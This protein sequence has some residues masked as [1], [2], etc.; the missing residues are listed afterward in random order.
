MGSTIKKSGIFKAAYKSFG[1]IAV[2]MALVGVVNAAGKKMRYE[3]YVP[4]EIIVKFKDG[5]NEKQKSNIRRSNSMQL[6]ETK[7]K[8]QVLNQIGPANLERWKLDGAETVEKIQAELEKLADVKYA[9]PNFY[10]Y[11]LAIPNDTSYTRQWGLN[12]TGQPLDGVTGTAGS[13]ME[14]EE[15]WDIQTGSSAVTVAVVDDGVQINHPDLSGNIGAGRD[16]INSDSDASPHNPSV[17]DHGTNAAGV[18]GAVGNNGVGVTGVAWDVTIMPVLFAN[19]SGGTVADA[20]SAFYWARTNGA[21]IINYSYGSMNYS[22]TLVDAI[23]DL[24]TNGVLLVVPAGNGDVNNDFVPLYPSN[25]TNKNI[26]AVAS[27]S[28]SDSLSSWS[29]YGQTSVDV[30]APGENVCTTTTS[31]GYDCDDDDLIDGTSF[32]APYVAGVAALIK[33]QHTSADYQEIKGRIMAGVDAKTSARDK[34]ASG[35]RVNAENALLVTE[36]EVL[37]INSV[38]V[39]ASGNGIIDPSETADLVIGIENVWAD[40]T[41][42]AAVLSS[43]DSEI[44]IAEA[45]KTYGNISEGNS[46]TATFSITLGSVSGYRVI[47]FQLDITADGY[48]VTRYFNLITGYLENNTVVNGTIQSSDY[49]DIHYYH[50]NVPTG[51]S[52]ITVNSTCDEDIDLFVMRGNRPPVAYYGSQYDYDTTA[53]YESAL[54]SSGNE[55]VTISNPTPG[56]YIVAVYN[57]DPTKA[58]NAYTIKRQVISGGGGVDGGGGGGNISLL[59]SIIL[60]LIGCAMRHR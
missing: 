25:H 32:S 10:V 43:S 11:P 2:S 24:E 41:N 48:S 9:E 38:S 6:G 44:S 7:I 18:L 30:M 21:Q 50:F 36:T 17:S 60:G 45:N 56:D 55:Q 14:M 13:D 29:Q 54:T 16:I 20:V 4:G 3:R 49:D 31:S 46:A 8:A 40:S 47:P 33:S 26:I 23:A 39:D 59:I 57:Y 27:S 15:A 22:Q 37:V 12:N 53:S 19:D 58:N 52:S 35:G 51:T 42:V 1:V 28:Q 5:T 34:I